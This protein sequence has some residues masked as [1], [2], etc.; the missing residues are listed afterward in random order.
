MTRSS[1][2]IDYGLKKRLILAVVRGDQPLSALEEIGINIEVEVD[3]SSRDRRVCV[4]TES[5]V[6]VAPAPVDIATGLL[7][8]CGQPREFKSWATFILSASDVVD[9]SPLDDWPE[10]DEFLNGL[11]DASFDGSIRPETKQV[12]EALVNG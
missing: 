6:V 9:L 5:P 2:P 1:E 11:W 4:K 7:A 8:H 3:P 10:G 12:A